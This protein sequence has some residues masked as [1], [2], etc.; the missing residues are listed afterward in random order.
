MGRFNRPVTV[1]RLR[2]ALR[3]ALGAPDLD[4]RV[5]TGE[6]TG[7]TLASIES[8]EAAARQAAADQRRVRCEGR[9]RQVEALRGRRRLRSRGA[10]V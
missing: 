6:T 1:E 3:Q 8:E 7:P 9:G 2:D 5:E 4:L 10:A